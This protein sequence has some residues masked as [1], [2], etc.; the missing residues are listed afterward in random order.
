MSSGSWVSLFAVTKVSDTLF[1]GCFPGIRPSSCDADIL[2]KILS[3]RVVLGILFSCFL[4][5]ILAICY[6]LNWIIVMMFFTILFLCPLCFS[7][8]TWSW[9]I[10]WWFRYFLLI[11]FSLFSVTVESYP[12]LFSV[13]FNSRPLFSLD[14]Y[15]L[16][17]P[18]LGY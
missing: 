3:S 5:S 2:E 10:R 14:F 7:L 6:H 4:D 9:F 17:N 18:S 1:F 11:F 12:D 15:L 8:C 16:L 13:F